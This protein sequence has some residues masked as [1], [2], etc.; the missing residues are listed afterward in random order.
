M[1]N[2]INKSIFQ[3]IA[4]RRPTEKPKYYIMH[5]DAGSMSP[6]SYVGWL[7]SRYDND[8]SDKGFAHYYINRNT[9]ARVEDT[10]NGSW[11]TAN[12]DGNM[13]SIGYEVCQQ[14]GSTDAEFLAN[15]DMVLRQ[16]AEDMT[17]YGDTPNYDNIK[18]HNEFSSTSC[19]ARSLELHGGDNDSLRD[20]VIAKIKRYQSMGSTVEEM[21]D[22]SSVTEGWQKNSTGWWYQ[23][24]D[25]SYPKNKFAKIKD[26]WYYF[27]DSGYSLANQWKKHTDGAWY[28]F[29]NTGAMVKNGW[30]NINNKWYY[31]LGEG[32]MKTGWLKDKDK[33]YFLDAVEGYMRTDYMVKGADGWYY[34]G[35]DG[36]MVTGKTI[37]INE[38]GVLG[39]PT[40][41]EKET[42]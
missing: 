31:F 27:N 32:A 6:D 9:I 8:E 24:S 4:G 5:N 28:Y 7:Q 23:Y 34:L 21:L 36:V 14:F 15:E 33:W 41:V 30:K 22:D 25:G 42:K 38:R 26:V 40:S 20:Y 1:V 29:D 12:Y 16:M 3:G 35:K 39:V 17:Y 19:P 2:V 37:T 13:N 10:Y 11:S 18:F